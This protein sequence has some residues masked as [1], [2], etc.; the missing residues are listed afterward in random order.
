MKGPL[1]RP[2]RSTLHWLGKVWASPVTLVG[3]L[4]GVI[5]LALGSRLRIENNALVFHRYPFGPGGALV[6]GNVILSTRPT[7]DVLVPTYA[8]RANAL[9]KA[10]DE[11]ALGAH[12]RDGRHAHEHVWLADHERAHTYQY[13]VLG[14]LFLPLYLLSGGISARNRFEQAADRYA[15]T[16]AG[17]WPYG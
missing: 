14:V 4:L 13:E 11:F 7:L 3:G 17:W 8:A 12:S 6:L 16:G 15:K 10:T 5:G 2:Q 1:P 9:G